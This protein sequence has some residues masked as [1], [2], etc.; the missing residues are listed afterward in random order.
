MCKGKACARLTVLCAPPSNQAQAFYS[1]NGL[2]LHTAALTAK[3]ARLPVVRPPTKQNDATVAATS[4][5]SARPC[6]LGLCTTEGADIM[7]MLETYPLLR[8]NMSRMSM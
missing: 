2:Q 6:S 3:L 5:S 4:T 1:L 8:P 7:H